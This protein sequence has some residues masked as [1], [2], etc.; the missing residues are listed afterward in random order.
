MN[1]ES[2]D[3]YYAPFL[4]R[5]KSNLARYCVGAIFM[6][7]RYLVEGKLTEVQSIEVGSD[8]GKT[9][10]N[11]HDDQSGVGLRHSTA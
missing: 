7:T 10:P 9:W 3:K 1:V 6:G 4:L 8:Y 2:A 11:L 5:T